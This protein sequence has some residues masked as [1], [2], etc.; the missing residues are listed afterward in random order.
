M[1]SARETGSCRLR[2]RRKFICKRVEPGVEQHKQ[3]GL[4]CKR[5]GG[6]SRRPEPP[7]YV[8]NAGI[9]RCVPPIDPSSDA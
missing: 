5:N 6:S 4:G 9:E 2:F 1:P 3:P 7:L 8:G